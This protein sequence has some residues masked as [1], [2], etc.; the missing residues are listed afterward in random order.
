MVGAEKRAQPLSELA[1]CTEW[2]EERGTGEAIARGADLSVI[3][4]VL[5][6]NRRAMKIHH[7]VQMRMLM[8]N[9]HALRGSLAVVEATHWLWRLRF[10]SGCAR[11]S[12]C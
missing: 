7:E 2:S 10:V 5:K 12:L 11:H 1:M 8:P 4:R 9:P 3:P 6:P